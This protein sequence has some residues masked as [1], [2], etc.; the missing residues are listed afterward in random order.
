MNENCIAKCISQSDI[1]SNEAKPAHKRG[2]KRGRQ[3]EGSGQC[4]T[5]QNVRVLSVMYTQ[6]Q[7]V[8]KIKKTTKIIAKIKTKSKKKLTWRQRRRVRYLNDNCCCCFHYCCC[9]L[10]RLSQ[11]KCFFSVFFIAMH[12]HAAPN[13]NSFSRKL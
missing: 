3:S 12:S 7:S 11:F 5:G 1:E 13:K 10:F 4:K 6:R 8:N 9:F 2:R